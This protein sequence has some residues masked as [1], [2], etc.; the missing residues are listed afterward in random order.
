M[1]Q[2]NLR[3]QT[4]R[5]P[6]GKKAPK[7]LDVSK[8]IRQAILSNIFNQLDAINLSSEDPEE[9]WTVLHKMVH[10]STATTLGYLSRKHQDWFDENN[11][12]V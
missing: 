8:S 4:A 12:E 5:R 1:A 3:I 2:L 6:Q 11:D 9:N 10:S 7:R